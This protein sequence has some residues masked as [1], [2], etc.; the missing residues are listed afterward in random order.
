VYQNPQPDFEHLRKRVYV[1]KYFNYELRN[2]KNFVHLMGLNLRDSGFFK[3]TEKWGKGKRFLDIGCAT[4]L[5]LAQMR[6]K[7]W[8]VE[9]IE[10]TKESASY[11]RKK[12]KV[13][14]H[15][16]VLEKVNFKKETF[17]AIHMSHV[18]EHVPDPFQTLKE[19]HRILKVNGL[20]LIIT[21]NYGSFQAFW[22]REKW[23]SAHKDHLTLFS[24]R[25]LSSMLKQV[26]FRIV[27]QYSYGGLAKGIPP[28][29]LKPVMDRLSRI[30]N[31]GDV[32]VFLCRK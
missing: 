23:R 15:N 10:L 26:G 13:K 22:F 24:I 14:V 20:F 30:F 28:V 11:A 29:F 2:E 9:G 27:C 7:G 1:K 4:G 18:I 8:L 17:D 31:I 32:M 12:Y 25:T 16:N 21:P 19:I 3:L 6:K 5:L